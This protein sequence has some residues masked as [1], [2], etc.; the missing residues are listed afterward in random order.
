MPTVDVLQLGDRHFDLVVPWFR[1]ILLP[2]FI[3]QPI[4]TISIWA[5]GQQCIVNCASLH[6]LE[7]SY[8]LTS[9]VCWSKSVI[10][11][12]SCWKRQH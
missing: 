10:R 11:I 2:D 1:I 12:L 7:N 9:D 5:V 8:L 3:V 6:W 4:Q